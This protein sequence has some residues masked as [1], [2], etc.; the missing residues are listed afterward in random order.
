M[1]LNHL[2]KQ[3]VY[4][5]YDVVNSIN[6]NNN[7]NNNINTNN[8]TQNRSQLN[9]DEG[10]LNLL[11]GVIFTPNNPETSSQVFHNI[12]SLLLHDK[13]HIQPTIID[14]LGLPLHLLLRQL[15]SVQKRINTM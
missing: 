10:I 15:V 3:R 7:N 5:K 12:I 1:Y 2:S 14:N 9:S 8:N 6:Q 13:E 11:R 4:H